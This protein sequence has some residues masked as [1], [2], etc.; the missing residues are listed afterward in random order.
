MYGLKFEK[1]L[2][3]GVIAQSGNV[4]PSYAYDTSEQGNTGSTTIAGIAGCPT[5]SYDDK[6]NCVRNIDPEKLCSAYLKYSVM[7][8]YSTYCIKRITVLIIYLNEC[9]A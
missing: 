8:M 4:L 1:G 6:L 9:G 2:F 5:S 3:H 7:Y